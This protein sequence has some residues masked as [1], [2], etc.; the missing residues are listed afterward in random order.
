MQNKIKFWG[1]LTDFDKLNDCFTNQSSDWPSDEPV[2]WTITIIPVIPYQSIK[3]NDIDH[4]QLVSQSYSSVPDNLKP[5][6]PTQGDIKILYQSRLLGIF[7][8]SST[9]DQAAL[10]TNLDHVPDEPVI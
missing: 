3:L 5:N 1:I 10:Q 9:A 7:L 4:I 2:P 8:V 6:Q